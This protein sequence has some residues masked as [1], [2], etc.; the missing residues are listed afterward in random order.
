MGMVYKVEVHGEGKVRTQTYD[1]FN[2]VIYGKPK[3]PEATF[4]G[5]VEWDAEINLYWL[6]DD[7]QSVEEIKRMFRSD[8]Q[9]EVE[10]RLFVPAERLPAFPGPGDDW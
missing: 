5:M 9:A 2:N 7:T 1:G 8:Y 10:V 3:Q 6:E 4:L